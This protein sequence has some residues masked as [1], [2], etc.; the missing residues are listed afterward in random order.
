MVLIL[1]LDYNYVQFLD[2]VI[3][4]LQPVRQLLYTFA[5][6]NNP[7]TYLTFGE[8]LIRQKIKK[9]QNAMPTI[10]VLFLILVGGSLLTP[11]V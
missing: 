5:I 7:A 11:E 2:S 1:A 4:Y 9:Y 8:R 6:S 3:A 10:G